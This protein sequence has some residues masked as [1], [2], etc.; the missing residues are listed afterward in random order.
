M[1]LVETSSPSAL[2]EAR[3]VLRAVAPPWMDLEEGAATVLE[4]ARA[5]AEGERPGGTLLRRIARDHAS[6]AWIRAAVAGDRD[7]L[8]R[9]LDLW[10]DSV[11]RWTR[12]LC[13]PGVHP[14]DAASDA[15]MVV[16]TDLGKLGDPARF[17]AWLWSITWRTV[18]AYHR[19]A[20]L[21]RWVPGLA[22]EQDD[23]RAGPERRYELSERSALVRGVLSGLKG[24]HQELL[25]LCYAEGLS[26]AE[27]AAQ[28]GM[29][30]GTLNRKLTQA[31]A[32]FEAAARE[33]GLAPEG[34][35]P[36][37]LVPLAGGEP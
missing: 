19:R 23:P 12:L 13:R 33:A 30:V 16:V 26:R 32:A 34:P 29:P 20:F 25:W 28:L 27:L 22:P 15:L 31:R 6:E 11:L 4:R 14:E 2:H 7:A 8:E 10:Q 36:G 37:R 9:L 21:R 17:R 24:E 3:A 1:H 35:T 18:R 5:A